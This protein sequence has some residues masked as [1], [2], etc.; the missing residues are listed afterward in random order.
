MLGLVRV[1]WLWPFVE[2]EVLAG[3]A[4]PIRDRDVPP[5]PAPLTPFPSLRLRLAAPGDAGAAVVGDGDT[6]PPL[7]FAVLPAA[8]AFSFCFGPPRRR[9]G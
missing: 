1:P 9:L 5:P 7:A 4:A 8:V 2:T 6:R 3:A